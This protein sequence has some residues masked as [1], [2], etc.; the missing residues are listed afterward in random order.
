MQQRS[1]DTVR[2]AAGRKE[3]QVLFV[4]LLTVIQ[5]PSRNYLHL[6]DFAAR[7]HQFLIVSK[8]SSARFYPCYV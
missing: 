2:T 7:D 4:P 1:A 3:R 6:P 8:E 5:R